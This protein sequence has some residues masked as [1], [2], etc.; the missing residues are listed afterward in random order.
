MLHSYMTNDLPITE[1]PPPNQIPGKNAPKFTRVY[2]VD[3]DNQQI[4]K[5]SNNGTGSLLERFIV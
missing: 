4:I 5:L 1:I 3:E 2:S